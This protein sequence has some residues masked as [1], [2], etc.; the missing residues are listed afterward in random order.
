MTKVFVEQPLALPE[1]AK[2]VAM[3]IIFHIPPWVAFQLF[4]KPYNW[5]FF[6]DIFLSNFA[7]KNTLIVLK[8]V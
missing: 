6:E 4:W 3:L 7:K 8:N 1:S 2:N 5:S